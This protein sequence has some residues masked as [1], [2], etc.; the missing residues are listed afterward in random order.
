[1]HG[2]KNVLSHRH[3]SFFEPFSWWPG[4]SSI[5]S[6]VLTFTTH[7]Q[8]HTQ[9]NLHS[10]THTHTH[11]HTSLISDLLPSV[12]TMRLKVDICF[13]DAVTAWPRSCIDGLV[14][15]YSKIRLR[16]FARCLSQLSNVSML[17]PTRSTPMGWT[18]H[19]PCGFRLRFRRSADTT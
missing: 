18:H 8:S 1:M 19:S 5:P 2:I 9:T 17:L 4:F 15:I 14:N 6:H 12:L 10:D 7:T 13:C 16:G 11:T 3:P